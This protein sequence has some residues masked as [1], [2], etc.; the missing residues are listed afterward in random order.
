VE[1]Q[2]RKMLQRFWFVSGFIC[3]VDTTHRMGMIATSFYSRQERVAVLN[4]L[5]KTLM[6]LRL[7][8]KYLHCTV[9]KRN[10]QKQTCL[11]YGKVDWQNTKLLNIKRLCH[12]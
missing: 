1:E 4:A 9:G 8:L 10:G 2:E 6:K 3:P 12:N 7:S 5:E 11:N